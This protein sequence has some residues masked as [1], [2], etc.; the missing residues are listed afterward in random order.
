VS[1]AEFVLKVLTI[2][3]WNRQGPWDERLKLLRAG[4]KALDPHVVGLQEVLSGSDHSL[5]ADIAEG[6]GYDVAYGEAKALPGGISFGNAVLSRF[7]ITSQKVFPLPSAETNEVRSALLVELDT[8]AGPLP[9]LTTHLAWKFHHGFVREQQALALAR[10]IKDEVPI[11]NNTLPPVLTGD[12]NAQPNATEIRFL[13]GL[14]ALEGQS[15]YLADC[16][17]SVGEGHGYTFDARRNPFAAF[18]HEA[19]RRIDYI[20]VRGPDKRGRGL[21][22]NARVVLDEVVDGVAPSDHWGVF[23]EIQM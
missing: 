17:G 16:F 18:T 15:T 1:K 8:P 21:P 11:L 4:L 6:L 14:H 13:T 3:I 23:S 12:F 20:F 22:M 7:D 10:I 2:N 5:A 19:P 9:F